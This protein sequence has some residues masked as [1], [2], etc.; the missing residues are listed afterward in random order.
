MSDEQEECKCL[1]V[2][3]PEFGIEVHLLKY[4]KRTVV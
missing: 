3:L 2:G 1:P 4:F